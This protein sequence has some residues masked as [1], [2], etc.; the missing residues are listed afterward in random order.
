MAFGTGPYART[1]YAGAGAGAPPPSGQQT[2]P[3]PIPG[4]TATWVYEQNS[5]YAFALRGFAARQSTGIYPGGGI[6]IRPIADRGIMEITAW[7][8]DAT[9]L[10]LIRVDADGTQTPV[11]SGA[12]LTALGP[13]RRNLCQNP[14]FEAGLNGTVPDLGSPTLTRPNDGTAPRGTYYLK[15]TVAAAGS[16]G[17]VIPNAVGA[18]QDLTV[19]FDLRLSAAATSLTVQ[20]SFTDLDG[21]TLTLASTALTTDQINNSVAQFARQVLRIATPAAGVAATIKVIAGG[22][23]A[24]GAMSL[25]GIT[26]ERGTSSDG[27]YFDGGTYGATWLGT[28]DLSASALAP[29]LVIEDG[30]CPTDVPVQYQLVNGGLAGG[31][32]TSAYATLPSNE[33]VWLTHPDAPDEPLEVFVEK[34]PLRGKAANVAVFQAINDPMFLTIGSRRR[35]A[36]KSTE[37]IALWT[38][39]SEATERLVAILDDNRPVLLRAP[40]SLNYGPPLWLSLLDFEEDPDGSS[41]WQ[42]MLKIS[43]P[44]VQV[45][46]PAL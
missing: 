17:V 44:W 12:P 25:D 36:W 38:F 46:A 18:G 16:C 19:A 15:A 13:T 27:S 39:G 29:L 4:G 11:R 42:Q 23:P 5:T 24:G 40:A 14:S 22:M 37:S 1:G 7:W 35:S 8:P 33:I 45:A 9:V 28:A 10:S 41:P 34:R 32:M 31:R 26:I 30:E 20:A 6:S 43:A 21:N 2:L 3:P